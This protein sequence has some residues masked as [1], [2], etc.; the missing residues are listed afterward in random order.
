[1]NHR[2]PILPDSGLW[3][4]PQGRAEQGWPARRCSPEMAREPE[5]IQPAPAEACSE[6]CCDDGEPLTGWEAVRFWIGVSTPAA[7]M[8]ALM[9][10]LLWGFKP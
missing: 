5:A 3:V 7:V 4:S 10:L 6:F 9:A 1:M 8:A 2:A